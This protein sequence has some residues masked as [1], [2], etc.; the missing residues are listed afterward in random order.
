M[1]PVSTG[2]MVDVV[3]D[4]DRSAFLRQGGELGALMRRHDW[5]SSP[6]GPVEG[7]PQSLKTATAIVLRSPVPMVMLWGAD[8]IMLYN[9]GY[10]VFAGGRHPALL[11]SKVREGWP[12]VADFNDQVMTVGLA[13][14]T[15]AYKDQE[16]TLRRHGAPEQVFMDLDYSPV[17]GEDGQPAGV[18]AIV[19]ETTERVVAERRRVEAESATRAERDRATGVL[20]NMARR[21]SCSTA[22]SASS[23]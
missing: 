23:T 20:D 3:Q 17:L 7:W 4:G 5:A 16:L 21:S 9:D 6:L 13:G 1:A 2:W 12:E 11:G 14:G 19:I 22:S 10:S 15:L 18:L 8:G